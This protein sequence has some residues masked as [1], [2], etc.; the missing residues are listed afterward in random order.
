MCKPRFAK[1]EKRLQDDSCHPTDCKQPLSL[2]YVP[3][4][5][6]TA[7]PDV[8]KRSQLA[9]SNA[10]SRFRSCCHNIE[11]PYLVKC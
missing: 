4:M 1:L 10:R 11:F 5:V 9:Q 7:F 6:T 3:V 8:E 2:L